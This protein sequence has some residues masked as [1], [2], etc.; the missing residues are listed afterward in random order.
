MNKV[1]GIGG[2]LCVVAVGLAIAGLQLI[3]ALAVAETSFEVMF[4]LSIVA[5]WV[6]VGYCFIFKKQTFPVHMRNWLIGGLVLTAVTVVLEP[7]PANTRE[8]FAGGLGVA[9]WVP[10]L[11]KSE[12]VRSTFV[13]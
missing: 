12:R 10:Y 2:W 8:L 11:R 4:L 3:S 5:Y 7:S 6:V 9:I 13:N 1:V